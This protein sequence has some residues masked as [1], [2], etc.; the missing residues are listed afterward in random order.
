MM[1][2]WRIEQESGCANA[3]VIT[4]G[5]MLDNNNAHQLVDLITNE[6]TNGTKF[7]ILDMKTLEFLS[8]AGVGA[9]L[10]TVESFRERGGDIVLCNLS[11]TIHHILSVLDLAEFLTIKTSSAEAQELC[12]ADKA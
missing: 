12:A 9:I 2:G 7:V 10:G 5:T 4:S 11:K 3:T 6:H 8:S 1:E